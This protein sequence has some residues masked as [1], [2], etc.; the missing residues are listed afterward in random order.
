MS[1]KLLTFVRENMDF[2]EPHTQLIFSSFISL[3]LGPDDFNA[4]QQ[5]AYQVSEVLFY[6]INTIF[7]STIPSFA[8]V[9]V[10][11]GIL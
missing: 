11:R 5:Q 7:T 10:S 4:R 3:H 6:A 8:G 2:R 9:L 1:V